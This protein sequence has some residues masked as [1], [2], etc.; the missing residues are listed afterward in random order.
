M[1]DRKA[2]AKLL[3]PLRD[4]AREEHPWIKAWSENERPT[5]RP[6]GSRWS[7]GKSLA[8]E[9]LRL[10]LVAEVK[11]DYLQSGR[12]R[13]AATFLRWRDDKPPAEC[14]YGQVRKP[15]AADLASFLAPR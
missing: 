13:H 3:Q 1:A 7:P 6:H 2:L 10:E 14:G 11:F 12:F 5:R 15:E 8:W 4:G 9:P